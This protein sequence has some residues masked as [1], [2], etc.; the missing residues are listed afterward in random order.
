MPMWAKKALPWA[1]ILLASITA[2]VSHA[3]VSTPGCEQPYNCSV[4][5]NNTITIFGTVPATSKPSIVFTVPKNRFLTITQILST[6]T[7][8]DSSVCTFQ[9]EGSGLAN[10]TGP[11]AVYT[12]AMF[13]LNLNPGLGF[14][15][16]SE[17]LVANVTPDAGC[18]PN[19][20]LIGTL[21]T[22][23]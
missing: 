11:L 10:W 13:T 17:L 6:N 7:D 1:A 14:A 9:I 18:T 3:R 4:S 8:S 16:G 20:T 12:S 2:N 21:G 23:P 5:L 19:F 22:S 15:A